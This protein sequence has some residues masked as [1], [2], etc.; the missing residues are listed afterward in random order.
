MVVDNIKSMLSVS[1]KDGTKRIIRV[2]GNYNQTMAI[3]LAKDL[4]NNNYLSVEVN[5]Q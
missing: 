3:L 1:C 5:A 4:E 2:V